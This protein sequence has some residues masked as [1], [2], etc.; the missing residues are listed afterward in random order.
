MCGV[1]LQQCKPLTACK[2]LYFLGNM[3][4][5]KYSY[6]YSIIKDGLWNSVFDIDICTLL[7]AD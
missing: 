3:A 5:P 4:K 1:Y 2:H 7:H 6:S